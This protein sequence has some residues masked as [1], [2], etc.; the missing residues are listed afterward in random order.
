MTSANP[1]PQSL[2]RHALDSSAQRRCAVRVIVCGELGGT[3]RGVQ[4]HK[5]TFPPWRTPMYR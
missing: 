1:F 4:N 2:S 3:G 5:Q